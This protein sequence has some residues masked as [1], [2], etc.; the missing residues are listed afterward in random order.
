M[1]ECP[2]G[3]ATAS[4]RGLGARPPP[5]HPPPHPPFPSPPRSALN[6]IGDGQEYRIALP[7]I[8]AIGGQSSGKSSVLESLVGVDFLPRGAG[9]TTRRP[10]ELQLSNN[11]NMA[12]EELEADTWAEFAHKRDRKFFDFAE[13]RQEII[14]ETERAGACARARV[15]G[16]P[17]CMH[18]KVHSPLSCLGVHGPPSRP[19]N[20]AYLRP[21]RPPHPPRPRP[22]H[23]PPPP[24]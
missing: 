4:E 17:G 3:R 20:I 15:A 1:R 10:L 6:A 24:R 14:R 9:I 22:P 13:V 11:S 21:P 5:T 2:R 12:L 19:S 7:A 23:P 18:P 8:V 16:R